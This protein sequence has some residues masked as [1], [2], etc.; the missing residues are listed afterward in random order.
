MNISVKFKTVYER[1]DEL[2]RKKLNKTEGGVESYARYLTNFGDASSAEMAKR[3]KGYSLAIKELGFENDIKITKA[4]LTWIISLY[5]RLIS[6]KD[7]LT[8]YLR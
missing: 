7:P 6:Q 3:L 4:D 1:L 2:C 8:K 5:K